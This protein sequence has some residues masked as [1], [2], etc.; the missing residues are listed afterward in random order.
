MPP[1]PSAPDFAALVHPHHAEVYRPA[2]RIVATDADALGVTQQV[3]L[4]VLE[5]KV[6]LEPGRDHGPWLRWLA[7][8]TALSHLR[9]SGTRREKEE[10]AVVERSQE[11]ADE[12]AT[13]KEAR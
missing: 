13:W 6:S 1:I 2:R 8:R 12:Q 10:Q 4:R 9:A 5:G 11:R 7:A 3:F